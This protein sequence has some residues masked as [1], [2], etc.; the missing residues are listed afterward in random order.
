MPL[1]DGTFEFDFD[2]DGSGE[3]YT[4][5]ELVTYAKQRVKVALPD[6]AKFPVPPTGYPVVL[7]L[8]FAGFTVSDML[9]SVSTSSAFEYALLNDFG[10]ALAYMTCVRTIVSGA[11]EVPGNALGW[12]DDFVPA[13]WTGALPP[14]RTLSRPM[15]ERDVEFCVQH[16][17]LH[18]R[19]LRLN[20][21]Q[22]GFRGNSAGSQAG[23]RA[24]FGPDRKYAHGHVGQHVHSTRFQ[25]ACAFYG[26]WYWPA[27]VSSLTA[28]HF[29][30]NTG[31]PAFEAHAAPMS[32]AFPEVLD[33]C[34][35]GLLWSRP[36][37]D[38][39][40]VLMWYGV[41]PVSL[42]FSIPHA[43][44][45][46]AGHSAWPG[47]A[48]KAAHPNWTLGVSASVDAAVPSP[49][50]APDFVLD[51]AD[52]NVYAAAW[53][54]ANLKPQY[55]FDVFDLVSTEPRGRVVV[56]RGVAEASRYG[57]R[58]VREADHRPLRTYEVTIPRATPGERRRL[59]DLW[60]RTRFGTTPMLL[61]HVDDGWVTVV[62]DEA[63]HRTR[64]LTA[65]ATDI[66]VRLREV[67]GA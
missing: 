32:T 7:V 22:V 47:Y 51:E 21:F 6:P 39:L 34:S 19:R 35:A 61:P 59:Q 36:E 42:D 31:A 49:P 67:I 10:I 28:V 41:P 66:R 5:P 60:G 24:A 57:P 62:F 56:R 16:L 9:A 65:R 15:P 38:L 33:G 14:G 1:V 40:P 8:N 13:G 25:A 52:A 2:G 29:A 26:L 20:P 3:V 53:F 18:A 55:P 44:T 46:T 27:Y 4:P 45:E 63:E 30:A 58:F 17:R 11:P 12:P 50:Q 23:H 48:A 54:A 43:G 64:Q 37:N